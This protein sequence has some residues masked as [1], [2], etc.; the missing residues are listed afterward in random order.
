MIGTAPQAVLGKRLGAALRKK[1]SK[2]HMLERGLG[3]LVGRALVRGGHA[4][5][6]SSV[7]EMKRGDK[8]EDW[9][10]PSKVYG[11]L[12]SSGYSGLSGKLIQNAGMGKRLAT[13]L[14]DVARGRV[15]NGQPSQNVGAFKV[16]E[17][18]PNTIRVTAGPERRNRRKKYEWEKAETRR[19][20]D[21]GI[22]T[23]GLAGSA[24]A[25]LAIARKGQGS[26]KQGAKMVAKEFPGHVS[27][28][29]KGV[30]DVLRGRAP[31]F[32]GTKTTSPA[33]Q[34]ATSMAAA[35]RARKATAE[36][37]EVKKNET[38]SVSL[39]GSLP[40]T[41]PAPPRPPI[42]MPEDPFKIIKKNK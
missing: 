20:I 22:L 40:R 23:V 5:M 3:C 26:F 2:K 9:S 28:M 7:I 29:A 39:T 37:A 33:Q 1:R 6:L 12:T 18:S 42:K 8:L 17:N 16:T 41:T 30:V 32:R 27:R 31:N 15:N 10:D 21:R 14:Y 34:K 13:D 24:T 35:A 4:V 19:K 36:A 38:Y 11:S 25:A